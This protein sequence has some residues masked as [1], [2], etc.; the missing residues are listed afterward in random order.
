MITV[1]TFSDGILFRTKKFVPDYRYTLNFVDAWSVDEIVILDV[2]RRERKVSETFKAVVQKFAQECFV[3]IAVGG[4]IRSVQDVR[5]YLDVGADKV[6]LNTGALEKPELITEVA[7][8]FGRQC[9]VM[10][11]DAKLEHDTYNVYGDCGQK[12]TGIN[13]VEWAQ[14][15]ERLGAGEIMLNSIER[16]GSLQGYELGLCKAVSSS[17]NIPVLICGGAGNWRHFKDGFE[18]GCADAVCTNN[19][20][21]FTEAS[22]HSA[23]KY[24]RNAGLNVRV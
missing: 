1:L 3:P 7:K 22:I 14:E 23:K 4:N 5:A 11:I 17:V 19:I 6:V 24:L 9:V 16:D 10:S 2:S 8:S 15:C 18:Q 12:P 21:H 20:Y 13:V